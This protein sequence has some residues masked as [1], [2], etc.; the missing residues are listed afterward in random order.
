MTAG[1][2]PRSLATAT[3]AVL[4]GGASDERE[5]SLATGRCVVEA[6]RAGSP[7]ARVVDVEIDAGGDWRLGGEP[8]PAARALE[9]LAAADVFFLGLHGASGEDGTLQGFL[10]SNGCAYTGSGVRASALC[11]DKQ[12]LRL[13]AAEA[14]LRVAPGVCFSRRAWSAEAGAVTDRVLSL[15]PPDEPGEPGRWVVKPR[16]GGSSVATRVVGDARELA[17]AIEGALGVGE[18]ALVEAFVPGVEVSCGVLGNAEDELRA[19]PPIEI[20]PAEGRFFDYEQK[21]DPEGAAELCPA[22][23]LDAAADRRVRELAL[24]AHEVGGCDGYSRVDFIV[25]AAGDPVLLEVNTLPGLTERSLLPQEAAVEGMGY[26]AL[27]LDILDR[28]LR[29]SR[30]SR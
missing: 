23:S 7:P 2:A 29:L 1:A 14:G 16:C 25:P 11:M 18:H 12:A 17:P 21:Y 6:L 9:S 5:I 10:E 30:R 13:L 3:V 19:L 22:P 4:S 26:R 8:L 27:C 15:I 28:A 20:R 24:L